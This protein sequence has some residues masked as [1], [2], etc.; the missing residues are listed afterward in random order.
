MELRRFEWAEERP[1]PAAQA[2]AEAIEE[3]PAP[4]MEALEARDG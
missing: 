1:G 2:G 4:A 3:R